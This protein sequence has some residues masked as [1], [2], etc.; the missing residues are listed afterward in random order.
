[1]I[2]PPPGPRLEWSID[3]V[4]ELPAA[5]G[6]KHVLTCVDTFSKY[7]V[8]VLLPDKSAVTVANAFRSHVLS[9][10]GVPLYLR[11]DNGS[12]F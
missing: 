11:C 3:L 2:P 12:E 4:V 5:S 10:F 9:I 8:F 7:T 1:M 6:F